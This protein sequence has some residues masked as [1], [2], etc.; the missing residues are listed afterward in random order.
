MAVRV[1]EQ[2]EPTLARSG[3]TTT[4]GQSAATAKNVRTS[5]NTFIN[6]GRGKTGLALEKRVHA[7]TRSWYETG[8]DIQV[9]PDSSPPPPPPPAALH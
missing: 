6:R 8:E 9:R 3:V 1:K 4:D 2:A 7:L 5:S